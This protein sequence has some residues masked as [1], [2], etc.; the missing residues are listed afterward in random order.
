[1]AAFRLNLTIEVDQTGNA[2]RIHTPVPVQLICQNN[3]WCFACEKP[4]VITDEF[5]TIEQALIAG[6]GQVANEVQ[7][8]VV[9][10]PFVAGRIT[11]DSVYR[12]LR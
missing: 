12:M 5:D 2:L 11:N 1:M 10:R 7:A 8:A 4:P 3:H 6:A 9:E